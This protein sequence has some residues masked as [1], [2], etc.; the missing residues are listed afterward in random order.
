M[1]L[2]F[3]RERV[4]SKKF[5]VRENRVEFEPQ[6]ALFSL[7]HSLRG[8]LFEEARTLTTVGV[9]PYTLEMF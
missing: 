7:E 5:F 2:Q 3:L 4:V 8:Q 6:K 1:L 9:L